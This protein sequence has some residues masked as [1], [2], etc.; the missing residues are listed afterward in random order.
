MRHVGSTWPVAFACMLAFASTF[1]GVSGVSSADRPNILFFL[2]DDQRNDQM[3]AAGHPILETP[4]MDRLAAE[5]VRFTNAFVTTSICA[6]SRATILTGLYER[7]HRFT[8]GTPPLTRELTD[9]GYAAVLRDAGYRTGFVG[10]IG[11]RFEPGAVEKMFDYY[12]TLDRDPYFREQPDGTTRHIS[13]IAGDKAIEFLRSLDDKPFSLSISFNAPHAEDNDKEDHYPWP[14][15]M[16]GTYD[17]VSVPAPRLSEPSVF[18]SQPEFLKDSLNRERWYWRWATPETYQK[19]IKGYYRMVSG[20][21]HVMGRVLEEIDRLGLAENTV[22]VFSSDNGYYLGSRG[23][24]GKWS[25]Y[26]ESL[27]VPLIIYD[28]REDAVQRGRIEEPMA[29]NVDI[30]ATILAIA[31]VEAPVEYQGVSLMPFVRGEPPPSWRA[32]FFVEH[33]MHYPGQI[34]KWEGLRDERYVYA[35]YFEQSPPFEF[36]H[37]LEAD[38]MQLVNLAGDPRYRGALDRARRRTD[39]LRNSYGGPFAVHEEPEPRTP[40]VVLIIS[41][42]RV[43]RFRFHGPSCHRDPAHRR[44]RAGW[45]GLYSRLRTHGAV[46]RFARDARN[47]SLSPPARAHR[48]RSDDPSKTTGREL[49]ERS[50]L[51]RAQCSAHHQCRRNSYSASP[52]RRQRLCQLPVRQVVGRQL[53]SRR[54]HRWHDPRRS[55]PRRTSW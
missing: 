20:V 29:L 50:S 55:E 38:P 7:S 13:Q 37:D 3:G 53:C 39:T 16:D 12:E 9:R 42:D 2:S 28:P 31:G 36:L 34:P 44:A 32:D 4:T 5:G 8:F 40:N 35:T 6:A 49:L 46:P 21:D 47:A 43:D 11:V 52:P 17:D 14:R 10:K 1:S 26:E 45:S 48:K 27:R 22:V 24:A 25:H 23:F 41:D 19:N 18:E 15:V 30:P 54:V 51:P 33:L